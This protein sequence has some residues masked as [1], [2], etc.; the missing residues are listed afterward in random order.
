MNGVKTLKA[1]GSDLDSMLKDVPVNHVVRGVQVLNRGLFI[2]YFKGFR[3]EVLGKKRI[4]ELVQNEALDKGNEELAQLFMTL[5]NRANGKLYHSMYNLVRTVNEE[6]DKIE[7]V[8]DARAEEFLEEL[9]KEFDAKRIFLSVL[10]N[11]VKFSKEAIQ[12][13]LG[14]EVPLEEWPPPPSPEEEAEGTDPAQSPAEP[15]GDAEGKSD[16]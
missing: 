4:R 5:W 7:L 10:F 14:L 3:L 11:E 15:A 13:K 2:R 12:K 16:E 6:V 9:L 1:L 8:E